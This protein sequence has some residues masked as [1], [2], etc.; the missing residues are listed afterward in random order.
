MTRSCSAPVTNKRVEE[1]VFAQIVNAASFPGAT[2]VVV[3]PD[4]HAGYGVPIG[5]AIES[6]G[7][8]LPT[9]AVYDIGCDMVQLKTSLEWAAVAYKEKRRFWIGAVVNRIGVGVGMHGTQHISSKKLPENI[10][11]GAKALGRSNNIAERAH[12]RR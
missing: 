7:T 12:S 3:T 6:E 4:C 9:A 2:R 10:R 5:T 8:L 11:H 1:E